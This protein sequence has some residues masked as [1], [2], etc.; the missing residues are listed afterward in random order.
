MMKLERWLLNVWY[1]NDRLGKYML[2]PLTGLFCVLAAVRRWQHKRQQ[3]KH[4]VPVIVVGNISVGGTGKTPLVIWLVERLREAGFK[5]G[6]VSRGYQRQGNDLGDEP[7]LIKQ[8]TQVPIAI[9]S[10]RNQA[11][12]T[13]LQQH[14]CD[15]V[16]A[17]DGLQHY[18]MGRDLEI[19]V[20]DGQRRFGNGWC[21]PSG[22]L[23]ESISRLTSCDFVIVNGDTMQMRGDILVN[24]ATVEAQ[25]LTAWAGKTVHV[26]TGIGNPQRFLQ[27]LEQAGLLVVPHLY[28]DHHAFTG[29]E[30]C[31][32]DTHPIIMTEKDAV[33]CR[34]FA[35]QNA[36]YLPIEAVLDETLAHA[37]LTRLQGF[38]HG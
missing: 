4:P 14:A 33:K 18:R 16:I 24:L 19:C 9:G 37:L 1:G 13:L 27:S 35:G 36:W 11:I 34:Q 2:L 7:T 12:A 26:V 25:P 30:L 23:R 20:V 8:R 5:P 17:D 6:V 3:V 31:F 10:D 29:T 21:L 15:M 28:P 22:P 38:K 32:D